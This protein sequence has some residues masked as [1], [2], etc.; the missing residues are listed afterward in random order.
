MRDVQQAE[1]ELGLQSD[2]VGVIGLEGGGGMVVYIIPILVLG[3]YKVEAKCRV[4]KP[5][6]CLPHYLIFPSNVQSRYFLMKA[7]GANHVLARD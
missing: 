3:V 4:P 2:L 7:F 6:V 5:Y 1:D